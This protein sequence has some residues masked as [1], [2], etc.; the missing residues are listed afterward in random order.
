M[1]VSKHDINWICD[2]IGADSLEYLSLE[3]MLNSM[4]WPKE[5]FCM[6][7]FTGNY[8]L[9]QRCNFSKNILEK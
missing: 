3:G 6:A 2:F 8:P 9:N 1:V 7:C 4:P 5:N